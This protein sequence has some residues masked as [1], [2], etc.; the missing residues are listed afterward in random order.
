VILPRFFL[1]GVLH[2]I[3][4]EEPA[5][6]ARPASR[7][8]RAPPR[9]ARISA[10]SAISEKREAVQLLHRRGRL[11]RSAALLG[12]APRFH[13]SAPGPATGSYYT[14]L[15]PQHHPGDPSVYGPCPAL[16]PHQVHNN[17]KKR[18]SVLARVAGLRI[19]FHAK[20]RKKNRG[21]HEWRGSV[22]FHLTTTP[23][24]DHRELRAIR[25][26]RPPLP[27]HVVR[28]IIRSSLLSKPRPTNEHEDFIHTCTSSIVFLSAVSLRGRF[29]RTKF[30]S[31]VRQV[32]SGFVKA[33]EGYFAP[34]A[35][36][37]S[38]KPAVD[39]PFYQIYTQPLGGTGICQ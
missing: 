7:R 18:R 24:R 17:N 31:N 36:R 4:N 32:T 9:S 8:T 39:Y 13:G 20:L 5:T 23:A 37:S 35:S 27:R 30:L 15:S 28:P 21:Y 12:I 34:T 38:I 6:R 14:A 25:G 19:D 10:L 29:H 26:A 1:F 3:Y 2:E 16:S 33:G 11:S 22:P